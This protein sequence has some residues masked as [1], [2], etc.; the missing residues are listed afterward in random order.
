[1]W[2]ESWYWNA[3]GTLWLHH[4][5]PSSAVG[6]HFT[7]IPSVNQVFSFNTWWTPA[8]WGDKNEQSTELALAAVLWFLLTLL[9]HTFISPSPGCWWSTGCAA[10]LHL[11][12]W[13]WPKGLWTCKG[14]LF[15]LWIIYLEIPDQELTPAEKPTAS[16]AQ[17]PNFQVLSGI[18]KQ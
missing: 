4:S 3:A 9:F 16:S 1:M 7:H 6:F 15:Q 18:C 17:N 5:L 2:K 10:S 8:W 14:W 13:A 12:L 11:G